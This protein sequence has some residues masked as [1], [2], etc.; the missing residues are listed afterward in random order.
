MLYACQD[1]DHDR[2]AGLR[3]LPAAIGIAGAFRTARILH[4]LMLALSAWLIHLFALGPIAWVGI[5]IV[6]LLL[7][8]EHSI[9]SPT[10]LTR[11]NAAFF[12]LNGY[13]SIVFFVFISTDLLHRR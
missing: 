8:Y 1:F 3:S 9:I 13:I 10:D 5:A 4:L 7:A 12:T 2:G 6:A 11:M